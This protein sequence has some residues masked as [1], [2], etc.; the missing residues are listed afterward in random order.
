MPPRVRNRVKSQGQD[1]LRTGTQQG[2]H[3]DVRFHLDLKKRTG[4]D[5]KMAVL[6]ADSRRV[7]P[8]SCM[9]MRDA[10]NTIATGFYKYPVA[11]KRNAKNTD[12]PTRQPLPIEYLHTE[13]TEERK[14][15]TLRSKSSRVGWCDT[16]SR[17]SQL[18][19]CSAY[20]RKI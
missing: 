12:R 18:V 19:E 4:C 8:R 2:G 20:T 15:S 5:L 7:K 9:S 3:R 17:T 11:C 16:G 1:L 6:G 10:P 13:C 14:G